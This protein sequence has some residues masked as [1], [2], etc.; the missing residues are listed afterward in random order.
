MPVPSLATLDEKL[1]ALLRKEGLD[2]DN[3][4]PVAAPTAVL[5]VKTTS[6]T[7]QE[8]PAVAAGPVA[9]PTPAPAAPPTPVA[10]TPVA[11]APPGPTAATPVSTGP[12]PA[13]P[14]QPA[15]PK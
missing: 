7:A 3:L 4:P 1:N 14:T 2:P 5:P 10:A 8:V 12:T 6:D 9:P 15:Q 11:P 13:A